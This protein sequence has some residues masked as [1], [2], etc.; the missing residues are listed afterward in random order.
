[1][2]RYRNL[3]R[4]GEG[5]H[6]VV[7]RGKVNETGETVALKKVM[8]RR[9]DLGITTNILREIE[10]LRV[11]ESPYVIRLLD[12]FAVSTG[13][14]LVLEYMVSD[15]SEVINKPDLT[16]SESQTKSYM[17]MLLRGVAHLHTNG[18]MHR[19]LKPANLLISDRGQL[20]I[21]DFGLARTFIHSAKKSVE[22]PTQTRLYSHQ[23][24]TRWYRSIELLYGAREYDEGMDNWAVGCIFGELLNRSPLFAGENDI[25]Q[26]YCVLRALGTPNLDIW[27]EVTCLPDYSKICFYHMDPMPWTNLV[28]EAS[29]GA[30]ELIRGFLALNPRRR[31]KAEEAL[32]SPF[33][34][35]EPLP[36]RCCDLPIVKRSEGAGS[37]PPNRV[38]RAP[39]VNVV[40]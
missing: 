36:A 40:I 5:A 20:K 25:D 18:I 38:P 9:V 7:F 31:L 14:M 28:P 21:A 19:D 17:C 33:F 35:L 3:G 37:Q 2:E 6:G 30:I 24:A 29:P 12:A 15:L 23:V 26:L 34:L 8:L 16:L 32:I 10:A 22:D 4:I 27:P 1:M 39:P 11:I 13:F